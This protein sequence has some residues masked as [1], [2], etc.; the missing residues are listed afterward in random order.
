MYPKQFLRPKVK[1]IQKVHEIVD[2]I[3]KN[4][5]LVNILTIRDYEL[6]YLSNAIHMR[7]QTHIMINAEFI[8]GLDNIVKF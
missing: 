8:C 6:I 5:Q 7:I 4:H 2:R 1:I 3:N